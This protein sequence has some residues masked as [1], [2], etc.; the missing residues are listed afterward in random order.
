MI[1]NIWLRKPIHVVLWPDCVC[2]H[3]PKLGNNQKLV[4][5]I[6]VATEW[7]TKFFFK[8]LMIKG[9]NRSV[10]WFSASGRGREGVINVLCDLSKCFFAACEMSFAFKVCL[11]RNM[12]T[13]GTKQTEQDNCNQAASAFSVV[14]IP[15]PSDP[16]P[17]CASAQKPEICDGNKFPSF[18]SA[19]RGFP[20]FLKIP[21]VFFC[22][23]WTIA[24][25]LV[26]GNDADKQ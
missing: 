18:S 23:H 2:A 5:I 3:L 19:P 25:W 12:Q 10:F 22:H 7:I 13:R 4:L 9:R 6:C 20:A 8:L 17:M 11:S 16:K 21:S 14:G 1:H 26:L 24:Q 15:G